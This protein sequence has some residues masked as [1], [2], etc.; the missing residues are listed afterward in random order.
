[1]PILLKDKSLDTKQSLKG[2]TPPK[3]RKY[4][5]NPFFSEEKTENIPL[6]PSITLSDIEKRY[7]TFSKFIYNNPTGLGYCQ[8]SIGSI[9]PRIIITGQ[10]DPSFVQNIIDYSLLTKSF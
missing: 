5:R 2:K 9:Y 1:M 6:N 3:M 7:L 10:A 8:I 4:R